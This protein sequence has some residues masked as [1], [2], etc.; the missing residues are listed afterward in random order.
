MCLLL[1]LP[2]SLLTSP[3]GKFSSHKIRQHFQADT[4]L[5]QS[6][7]EVLSCGQVCS[8]L[9]PEIC[10]SVRRYLGLS[11]LEVGEW[12]LVTSGLR[13]GM[14]LNILQCTGQPLTTKNDLDL[15]VSSIV[16]GKWCSGSFSYPTVSSQVPDWYSLDHLVSYSH[17]QINRYGQRIQ[18]TNWPGLG[19]VL[20]G[21][22]LHVTATQATMNTTVDSLPQFK[23]MSDT[24]G[25]EKRCWEGKTST[26]SKDPL[27][28]EA[29]KN[30]S[31]VGGVQVLPGTWSTRQD[32]GGLRPHQKG[33][34]EGALILRVYV[35]AH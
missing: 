35:G 20:T 34:T 27:Q 7:A 29:G 16:V 31:Q 26:C 30:Q 15:H 9:A 28:E 32:N 17:L 4:S 8:S 3:S 21:L 23:F 13:P 18:Y 33:R 2:S 5:F 10:G 12:L 6:S 11:Q 19:H 25:K 22:S 14:L 24:R 1:A